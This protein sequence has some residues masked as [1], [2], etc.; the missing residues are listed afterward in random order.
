MESTYSTAKNSGLQPDKIWGHFIGGSFCND[1]SGRYLQEFDPRNGQPSYRVTQGTRVDVDKAVSNAR[2]VSTDWKSRK[3]LD[4]G[5]ILIRIGVTLRKR[6]EEFARAEQYETGKPL[7]QTLGDLE[8]AA[9]YFEF[10]GGLAAGVEGDIID[11]GADRMCY[12]RREPYGT[13]G[14]ILPWNAPLN[15]AARSIAPGLAVGNTIVAKPSKSTSVSLL[16]LAEM[17][18]G[19]GLPPGVLNVVTGAGSQVGTPLVEHPGISKIYFTGSGSVGKKIAHIAAE[20]V[21]P[22][23]LELGGKSPNIVFAD[24]DLDKAVNGVISG[25]TSNAGQACIAGSRCLVDRSIHDRFVEKLGERVERLKIGSDRDAVIG[26][27]ITK[28]Q[29]DTVNEYFKVACD[30]KA[31]LLTGGAVADSPELGGGWYVKPTV[32][33]DVRPDMRIAQEEI[34][35]PVLV[36]TSFRDEAEAVTIANDSDYG[37]AAG[38]WTKDLSRAHRVAAL[39]ESGQVFINQYPATS[40][41]TPFGGYKKSGIGREKGRIALNDYIQ[42]KTVVLRID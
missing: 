6:L 29:F 37:L 34:F 11:I 19:C 9:Q 16:M 30:E 7:N 21:I 15:Q 38:I 42:I 33:A 25:F 10:Y 18:I 14:V 36:V 22:V 40:V 41:E 32:Y 4:R 13:I 20:R 5:R 24:A 1:P 27:M 17:A 28:N 26:P 39:L 3:P 35:G 12:T 31:R 23:T 2:T 8:A